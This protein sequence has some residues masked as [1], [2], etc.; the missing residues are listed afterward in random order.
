M[1]TLETTLNQNQKKTVLASP[2]YKEMKEITHKEYIEFLKA[3]D[4]VVI[5]NV[6]V[7]LKKKSYNKR[8]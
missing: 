4:F 3:Y 2:I 5:E 1:K 6:K 7:L 8:I